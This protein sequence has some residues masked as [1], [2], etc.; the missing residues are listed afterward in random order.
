[1]V[2]AAI[3]G[4]VG[5]DAG[6][7]GLSAVF[8]DADLNVLAK[9]EVEYDIHTNPLQPSS[10]EQSAS[11]WEVALKRAMCQLRANMCKA[12]N[13]HFEVLAIGICGQMHGEVLVGEDNKV[14]GRVR[15]WCDGRNGDEGAE[16]TRLF[17][18]KVPKRMTAARWLWTVRNNVE[19]AKA[20]HHITTPAGWL[21]HILTGEWYLG[22]GD[23][24]GIF[25]INQS[26]MNYDGN[27]MQVYDT[28]VAGYEVKLLRD[29]LPVVRCAGQSAGVLTE[30]GSDIM[31]LPVG[32]PVSPAEGDQPAALAGAFIGTAGT[33]SI[34]FGT[35]VVGNYV[36]D[37]PFEGV[38]D[39]IDHFCAPDGKP[40]NMVWLRNGTTFMNC[41]VEMFGQVM[42]NRSDENLF[43]ENSNDDRATRFEAVLGLVLAAEPDCGG[44]L[45][46]PFMHDEPGLGVDRGGIATVVGLNNTNNTPGN[47]IK[48]ALLSAM[49]NLRLGWAALE[50]HGNRTEE[51]VLSGGITRTPETGQILADVYDVPVSLPPTADEGCAL[52][53]AVLAKFLRYK[54]SS[55]EGQMDWSSFLTSL[56]QRRKCRRFLPNTEVV[57]KY[58]TVYRTYKRLLTLHTALDEALH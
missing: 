21:S 1:M 3:R 28:L 30:S 19:Q 57:P 42:G 52:G 45:A 6:T 33:V 26:T 49:F 7:Q 51:I 41:V 38:S 46:I 31:G 2:C 8:C 16:L 44:I 9:G 34:S 22:V 15:I 39:S 56:S 17:G 37:R 4:Y 5:I 36:C 27:L 48:A 12:G 35:S 40:I 53:S 47:M 50:Q 10:F 55:D 54:Q 20:V 13:G 25:P 11:D 18:V 29:M 58:Q 43:G 32:V 23:A 14:L 24:S